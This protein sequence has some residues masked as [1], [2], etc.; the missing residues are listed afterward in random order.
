MLKYYKEHKAQVALVA[1]LIIA[2]VAGIGMY[3]F[4]APNEPKAKPPIEQASIPTTEYKNTEYNFTVNYPAQWMLS[5]EDQFALE[6]KSG[7]IVAMNKL[8]TKALQEKYSGGLDIS[9][10]T[11]YEN[12]SRDVYIDNSHFTL[13]SYQE[14]PQDSKSEIAIM[15]AYIEHFPTATSSNV[16]S[17][18]GKDGNSLNPEC[19]TDFLSLIKSGINLSG[20]PYTIVYT[21][22]GTITLR[23]SSYVLGSNPNWENTRGVLVFTDTKKKETVLSYVDLYSYDPQSQLVGDEFYFINTTGMLSSFNL[24]TKELRTLSLA[25]VTSVEYFTS[26]RLNDFFVYK[27]TVF[28]L[29]GDNCN[30]YRAQC[31]LDLY[32][33]SLTTEQVKLLTSGVAARKILGFDTASQKI[34]MEYRDGDAGCMWQSIYSFSLELAQLQRDVDYGYC[35]GDS[36]N[37]DALKKVADITTTLQDQLRYLKNILVKDGEILPGSY[38]NTG[39][40]GAIRYNDEL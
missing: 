34:Y 30:E 37:T 7:C 15:G 1:L 14:R 12:D 28:Y 6:H 20:E 24:L 17:V 35:E 40:Y 2:L 5:G 11:F 19:I 29:A 25:G 21:S 16:L 3:Y 32:A 22:Q 26:P 27:D 36:E 31:N 18:K 4:V 9:A 13:T 39:T 8:D 38:V 23:T 10:E 33:Y